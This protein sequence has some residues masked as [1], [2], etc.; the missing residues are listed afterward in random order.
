MWLKLDSISFPLIW[1]LFFYGLFSNWGLDCSESSL[2]TLSSVVGE[3]LRQCAT[4]LSQIKP[5]ALQRCR[6]V[7]PSLRLSSYW[8]HFSLLNERERKRVRK[9]WEMAQ[10]PRTA[11]QRAWW[12]RRRKTPLKHVY[13][14]V[15][16]V[17]VRGEPTVRVRHVGSVHFTTLLLI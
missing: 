6:R 3:K 4:P 11:G 16:W 1:G 7:L 2:S 14:V 9:G 5:S 12:G 15:T 10:T 13:H 8:L 17:Q